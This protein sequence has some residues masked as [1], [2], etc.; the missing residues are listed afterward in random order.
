MKRSILY[1][2][3][4]LALGFAAGCGSSNGPT[5]TPPQ[6]NYTQGQTYVY[7]SQA[8]DA[9]T[10]QPSG[11]VDTIS[12][13]VVVTGASYQGMTNV[14]EIQNTHSSGS[15]MDTTYIAQNNGE[16]W[17]YNYGVETLNSN[18]S[19]LGFVN[20]GKPINAGWVLQAKLSA[21]SGDTWVG[22]NTQL[23][24]TAGS[25]NLTDSAVEANDTL[26]TLGS[27]QVTAK[28]SVHTVTLNA[29]LVKASEQVD[30]YVSTQDGTVVDV[31]HPTVL[32]ST[33]T[34][35]LIKVL[36]VAK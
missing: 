25:V 23:N 22:T 31:D 36:V 16:Y 14:T 8:L 30:T 26:I 13:E 2:S 15:G 6:V 5:S 1:I 4:L 29:G 24:L 20:S 11:A 9:T 12:S 19:V 3:G 21:N 32:A 27:G 7:T 34:P 35:G 18:S 28:H 33:P 17:H 10:G